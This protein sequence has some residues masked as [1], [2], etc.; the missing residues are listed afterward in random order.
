[1]ELFS[2]VMGALRVMKNLLQLH[3]L[4]DRAVPLWTFGPTRIS[5][6]VLICACFVGHIFFVLPGLS[7]IFTINLNLEFKSWDLLAQLW[8]SI[9]RK[10]QRI[11]TLSS[12]KTHC[13]PWNDCIFPTPCRNHSRLCRRPGQGNLKVTHS[14]PDSLALQQEGRAEQPWVETPAAC[15]C[16]KCNNRR[17]YAIACNLICGFSKLNN[18]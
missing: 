18:P 9:F 8:E 14:S 3:S 16:E 17:W 11:T 12:W 2:T 5:G 15:D 13:R 1:M 4:T 6:S 10:F 7:I